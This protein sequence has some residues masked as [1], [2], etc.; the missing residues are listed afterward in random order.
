MPRSVTLPKMQPST[1]R[2]SEVARHVVIPDGIVTTGWPSIREKGAELGIHYDGWQDGAGQLIL[3]KRADGK[4][5]A[6]IGGVTMSIP[7]Q[8]GKTFF[9]GT[10]VMILCIIFPGLQVVWTAHRTRT[11]TLTFRSL[12]GMA[13]RKKVFPHIASIRT[14]NGEQ[15]IAFNNGSLIMFGARE[16][17]FGR[18]FDE[19]DI[20]VFDEAQILTE[21][22]LD[23]MIAATNQ[24]RH[25][26]G[27]LLF[28][29][30]TP[31]KPV[32]PG[33]AFTLR[34]A[35]ALSG[36]S[37]DMV[38]IECSADEDANPDDRAQWT[39]ANPSF[40]HRTPLE[41]MLRLRENLLNEDS[42]RREGLGI[43]DP[44]MLQ[45]GA[46][47]V[48]AWDGLLDLNA[49]MRTVSCFGIAVSRD[50]AW[51]SIGAAGPQEDE[52]VLLESIEHRPGADWIV[53]RCVELNQA[54]SPAAFVVDSVGPAAS[55]ISDLEDAGL[56]VEA[57][58][59][60]DVAI[61][62]TTLV[63]AVKTGTV[64]HGPQKELRDAVVGAK[65]RAIGDGMFALGRKA[66]G[67]EITQ[68]EAV[69]L[70]F[71]GHNQFG[72]VGA[73]AYVL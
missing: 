4:Y 8:V 61:A 7:R 18:G 73:S 53:T 15:E 11:T 71:W 33:E 1:R 16:Q 59:T 60:S 48:A 66:S 63:D 17:G 27:A 20:E 24:S 29:I 37:K 44:V 23:D 26:H 42:W 70:A 12:Q 43:W 72:A 39:K 5:A 19:V 34:R 47:N 28:F 10:L 38:F 68:L 21:K 36:K 62:Y 9:V 69:E 50:R 49:A 56:R 65:K 22:A 3:G 25:P 55:L 57:T 30:G 35:K 67:V 45:D 13:R 41:S 32:D 46:I 58:T 51:G 6:T 40:P 2:L 14:A 64:R 54:W 31:P 52:T